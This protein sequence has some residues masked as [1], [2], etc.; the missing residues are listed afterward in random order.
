MKIGILTSF[1]FTE[2]NYGSVLQSYALS[3]YLKE[4]GH[5]VILIRYVLTKDIKK[6]PFITRFRKY[7]NPL[8]LL[9]YVRNFIKNKIT[10]F[11]TKKENKKRNFNAFKNKHIKYTENIY[12]SFDELK[13]NYPKCDCYIVGSD[14]VWNFYG[15]P[16]IYTKNTVRTFFLDFGDVDTKRISYAAS[17]GN[18]SLSEEFETYISPLISKFD[19]ISVRERSGER[20]FANMGVSVD[21]VLDPIFLLSPNNYSRLFSVK[22]EEKSKYILLYLL[23]NK[24]N[25]S[26]RK[27]IKFANENNLKIVYVTGNEKLDFRKKN[28]PSIEEWLELISNA[29]CVITNSF[30]CSA[31]S[32]LFNIPFFIVPQVK[33]IGQND[34]FE[35]LLEYFC[36]SN[37][38]LIDNDYAKLSFDLNWDYVNNKINDGIYFVKSKIESFLM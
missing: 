13:Q 23:S 16:L 6:T 8:K 14:Q 7:L 28:Y 24:T 9:T 11:I 20:I 21:W 25:F 31:F 19:Y 30:H 5:D 29:Y 10:L 37:R 1:W 33:E 2:D 3:T 12:Y 36:L 35:S 32:I 15:V 26:M 27:L 4:K 17:F 38:Y 34:R 22:K 18:S